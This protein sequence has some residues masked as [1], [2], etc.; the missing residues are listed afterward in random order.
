MFSKNCSYFWHFL[1]HSSVI[2]INSLHLGHFQA[3]TISTTFW[4]SIIGFKLAAL[5]LTSRSKSTRSY[6]YSISMNW[7]Y[8]KHLEHV[9]DVISI[10]TLQCGHSHIVMVSSSC[11]CNVVW[12]GSPGVN[13]GTPKS[14]ENSSSVDTFD[15]YAASIGFLSDKSYGSTGL[16]SNYV[17]LGFYGVG[18]WSST[19]SAIT[20][21]GTYS[22]TT[23][24]LTTNL[25]GII[26][27]FWV[28]AVLS[29]LMSR[30]GASSLIGSS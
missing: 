11:C 20:G 14:A 5:T 4:G 8:F 24:V 2:C 27:G 30:V 28:T 10:Y 12:T 25:S 6:P 22:A 7:S 3:V 18:I 21:E 9:W 26:G 1:Q 16:G 23:L 29:G 17:W 19:S 13:S 15:L